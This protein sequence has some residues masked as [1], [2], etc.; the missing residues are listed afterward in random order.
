M[1]AEEMTGVTN[2]QQAQA[3]GLQ[4]L[5]GHGEQSCAHYQRDGRRDSAV[6]HS[7]DDKRAADVAGAGAQKPHNYQFV[8][9]VK[10]S[11]PNGIKDYQH[12]NKHEYRYADDAGL[13]KKVRGTGDLIDGRLTVA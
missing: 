10:D 9:A 4:G 7:F 13:F 8:A 1:L 2:I 3:A 11:H 5:A 12:A 6:G